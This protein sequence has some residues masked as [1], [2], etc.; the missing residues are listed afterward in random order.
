MRRSAGRI[1]NHASDLTFRPSFDDA[2]VIVRMNVLGLA[3][4]QQTNAAIT[5]VR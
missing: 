1:Q 2:T 4:E 3:P 5:E